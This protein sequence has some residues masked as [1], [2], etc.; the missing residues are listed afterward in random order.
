[1]TERGMANIMSK[2]YGLNKIFVESKYSPYG[3]GYLG[4]QLNVED[5]MSDMI[6]LNEIKDLSLINIPRIC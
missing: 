2:G 1:M 5:T 6:I 4:D 3:P